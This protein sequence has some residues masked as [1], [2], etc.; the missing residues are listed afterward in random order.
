MK[1]VEILKRLRIYARWQSNIRMFHNKD[2]IDSLKKLDC[3]FETFIKRSFPLSESNEGEN[4]WHAIIYERTKTT[5]RKQIIIEM[6]KLRDRIKVLKF[7][8]DN[9]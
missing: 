1:N 3:S 6:E 9:L 8:M 5:R 2:Y 7:E 4:Y